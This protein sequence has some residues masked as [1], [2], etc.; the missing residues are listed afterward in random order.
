MSNEPK[1][2][3][4]AELLSPAAQAHQNAAISAAVSEG[5]KAA[6]AGIAP[7]LQGMQLTPEKINDLKKP[8]QDPVAVARELRET[9]NSKAQEQEIRKQTLER[10]KNCKH[11]DKNGR[12]SLCLI[13]NYPDHQARGVCPLCHDIIHPREWVIDAPDPQTG[14]SK[15]HIREPH[16]DYQQVLQLESMS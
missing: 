9:Q 5:V 8:Y 1:H 7:I 16:R 2:E 11:M 13:H 3:T 4:P 6:L 14:E 10:Q 12:T 15:A